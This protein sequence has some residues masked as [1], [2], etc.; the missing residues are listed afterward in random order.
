MLRNA[1]EMYLI[2]FKRILQNWFERRRRR[3]KKQIDYKDRSKLSRSKTGLADF[4]DVS[5]YSDL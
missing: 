1:K 5:K 2:E 4:W 3:K